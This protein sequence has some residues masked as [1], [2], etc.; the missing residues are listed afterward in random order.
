MASG[1]R[2]SLIF[3]REHG[4]WGILL[5]PLVTGA[6]VGLLAGGRAWPLAPLSI[7]VLALF[8]VLLAIPA[9][10]QVSTGVRVGASIDPDQFYFGGHVE[11]SELVPHMRF[12][13]NVEIGIG[14]D[15][16]LIAFNFELAYRF[17]ERQQ[18]NPYIAAGPALNIM[19]TSGDTA[20][21]GGFNIALGAQH[22]G[23]LF[24]EVK[25]GAIDSPNFK[26][27]IG[28]RF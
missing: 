26:L 6:S 27:G 24:G 23:G 5:V 15:L 17:S 7:A 25:I 1:R 28:F 19:D 9:S 8:S 4:A 14:N 22:R 10:A 12:R 20:S 13:P 18:W 16:T 11:S 2:Q 3:P 21:H